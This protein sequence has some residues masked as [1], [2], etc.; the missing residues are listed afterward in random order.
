[1]TSGTAVDQA[2]HVLALVAH[3]QGDHA[4]A[5]T[6]DQTISRR[7]RHLSELDDPIL[8]SHARLGDIAGAQALA[9]ARG[10]LRSKAVHEQLR[11]AFERALII[12]SHGHV[13]IPFTNDAFTP[14]MPPLPFVSMDVLSSL[15]SIPADRSCMS[16]AVT[17]RH[18]A[19]RMP[20]ANETLPASR[21]PRS[22]M[23]SPISKSTPCAFATHPQ[24]H[25]SR[26]V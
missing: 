13:E 23:A 16:I 17:H 3:V 11:L 25:Q 7:Y 20:G 18:S 8:W 14:L 2:R 10:L 1:L 5:V 22:V 26:L 24:A 9:E 12:D 6:T 19:S 15:G 4:T 21:R